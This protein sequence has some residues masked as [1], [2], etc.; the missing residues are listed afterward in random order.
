M[1]P[2]LV[3]HSD[4]CLWKWFLGFTCN[5]MVMLTSKMDDSVTHS[6]QNGEESDAA[7]EE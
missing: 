6:R 1:K 4:C 7:E 3:G 2:S 5:E